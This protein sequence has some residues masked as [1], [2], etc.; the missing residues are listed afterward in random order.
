MQRYL[1]VLVMMLSVTACQQ[2]NKSAADKKASEHL[3]QAITVKREAIQ[4]S[5]L[6][7]GT[8]E[9]HRQV[10]IYNEEQGQ[11]RRLPFYPGD[12]V[13]A[14]DVL[15]ELD[16]SLISAQLDKARATTAQAELDLKRLKRL[17]ERKLTSEDE[18]ARAKTT[19][20]QAR[21]EQALLATRLSH[22]IIKAP[23]GGVIS[24]RLREPGD[25][26]PVHTHILTLHDPD[27][28]I[29]KISISELLLSNLLLQQVA[30]MRIDALG[31]Q[32]YPG[33]VTRIY[34]SVDPVT[35]Q[36]IIEIK[37]DPVPA[38][39]LPGQLV[40]VTLDARTQPIRSIPLRVVRF[41]AKGEFVY[42]IDAENRAIQVPIKTGAQV[43]DLVEVVEGVEEGDVIVSEGFLDLRNGKKVRVVNSSMADSTNDKSLMQPYGTDRE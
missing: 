31:D 30:Q 10:H 11:L 19:V 25:V 29:A 20:E 33:K 15:A 5:R 42:R 28:L 35:R 2:D 27:Q 39:A 37:L 43:N 6:I 32:S 12:R 24:E 41:D 18:L 36:G 26:L 38:G 4:A 3:V 14:G 8:L 9:P 34:P 22:T 40:R 1:W 7:T 13:A 16:N 23:F 17:M 21:A